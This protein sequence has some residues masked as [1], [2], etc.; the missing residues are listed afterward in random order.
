M[1]KTITF[2]RNELRDLY[3]TGELNSIARRI[4]EQVCDMPLH[5]QLLCKDRQLSATEQA[6]IDAIV[7]RLSR[8]EPLQY[9]LGY[10]D[11]C[12]M[13]L[14]V[15]RS[16][17]IPR[18]ETEELVRLVIS[19]LT[20]EKP[21]I[22]D[23]ATGSGCI[24][25]ALAVQLNDAEIYAT[26]ISDEALATARTNVERYAAKVHFFRSD[27]LNDA[28][29][30]LPAL[31]AIVSNPPYIAESEKDAM[32]RNVLDYEPHQALFVPDDDPLLFY[33][34]IA[35]LAGERLKRGGRLFLEINPRFAD[36][37]VCLLRDKGFGEVNLVRDM[38]N[39]E[40][41]INARI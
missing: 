12:G 29:T 39:K 8:A 28:L 11:F 35:T 20:V 6:Q 36:E 27:I 13:T 25:V 33:R 5:R 38:S 7:A 17:L 16:T 1:N 41:M 30:K 24:A 31:D 2:I 32:H 26:D 18:P 19:E 10:A 14:A 22:L 23:I 37:T 40:R 9:V 3:S 15:N 34:R 4:I 21:K